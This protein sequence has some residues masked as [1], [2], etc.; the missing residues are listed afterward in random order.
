[1]VGNLNRDLNGNL[2]G[3]LVRDLVGLVRNLVAAVGQ[4]IIV[5][6]TELTRACVGNY[7]K[8]EDADIEKNENCWEYK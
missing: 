7:I 8:N 3:N 1:L 2:V 4:V 6:K 5:G